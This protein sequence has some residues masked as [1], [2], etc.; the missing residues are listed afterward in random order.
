MVYQVDVS[1][2]CRENATKEYWLWTYERT[3]RGKGVY[4]PSL[5]SG[6]IMLI[7]RIFSLPL[8]FQQAVIRGCQ[9]FG[10]CLLKDAMREI[11]I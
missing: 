2:G 9:Y 5:P 8:S 1:Y 7:T 4:T 6:A 3:D 11:S 10:S